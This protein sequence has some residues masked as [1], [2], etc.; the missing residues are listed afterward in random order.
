[1]TDSDKVSVWYILDEISMKFQANEKG[2][3][4]WYED[5]DQA[6]ECAEDWT[7]SWQLIE[8]PYAKEEHC[9]RCG[10]TDIFKCTDKNQ[11]NADCF[12]CGGCNVLL[13]SDE[14]V[15]K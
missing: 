12:Q 11:A 2:E 7:D 4:I 10:S 13:P 6:R 9:P 5:K 8:V 14:L 15:R 1:M 3:L